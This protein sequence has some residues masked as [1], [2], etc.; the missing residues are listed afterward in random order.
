MVYPTG[1][2]ARTLIINCS[3]LSRDAALLLYA[4]PHEITKLIFVCSVDLLIVSN[5][6][7]GESGKQGRGSKGWFI[8]PTLRK[9]QP[10]VVAQW[11]E[12]FDRILKEW[13]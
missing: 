4:T 5:S 13:G 3:K 12:A 2:T 11:T 6:R 9:E 7:Y 8:Y 10:Y 1:I